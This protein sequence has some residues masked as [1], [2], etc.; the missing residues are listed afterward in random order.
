MKRLAGK[1][2]RQLALALQRECLHP[3]P[4]EKHEELVT[5]L[6]ELLLEALGMKVSE[7][8]GGGRD[9]PEDQR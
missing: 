1:S 7:Q 8:D 9:E 4:Q 5:A 2:R 6:A 3:L